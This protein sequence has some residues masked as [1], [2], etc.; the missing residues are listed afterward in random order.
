M[1]YKLAKEI[2][3]NAWFMD[4][5]SLQKFSGLL[6]H[7]RNGGKITEDTVKNNDSHIYNIKDQ[8]TITED[9]FQ[10]ANDDKG[11]DYISVIHI[12]GAITKNGGASSYGTVDLAN[13][14]KKFE[15]L[16]N[17]IGH[18]LYTESGGGSAN[19]IKYMTDV[20]EKEI[21]K[22]V[23]SYVED[24]SASAAYYIN[25]FTDYIIAN[26]KD[27][28]IGSIGTMIEMAG[29]PKISED[30]NDGFR[31]VRIYADEAFNKNKEFEEAINNL[32]FKPIKDK[33]LN[34]HND[35]FKQDVTRMR[36]NVKAEEL[37]GEIFMASEVV[38]TLIDAIGTFE[39]A[40]NKVIELSD[41][42]NKSSII[43]KNNLKMTKEEFK[44]E[45]PEAYNAI[46]KDERDRVEAFLEFVDVDSETV[47]SQITDGK[48]M[49]NKF[50]AEM[51]TK[52]VAKNLKDNVK[53]EAIDPLKTPKTEATAVEIELNA[54]EKKLDTELEIKE[55]E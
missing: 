2:Y 10:A 41:D 15:N 6:D 20:L 1:N 48:P 34:P 40:V 16:D 14:L 11:N 25:A 23:V 46:V 22:P 49:T 18:I 45:N 54:F 44:L 36:P 33:I 3:G 21:S 51:T 12:D 32:N 52:M 31:Y 4:A 43:N 53:A 30:K 7:I 28:I 35:K 24:M 13:R 8:T 19:A 37:T 27:A 47:K 29:Y 38:G 55:T 39:D 17:V 26:D 5:I 42:S 50:M 9:V